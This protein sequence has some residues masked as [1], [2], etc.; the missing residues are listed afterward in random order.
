M[1]ANRVLAV[2][3]SA[4]ALFTVV[5]FATMVLVSP[6]RHIW[7]FLTNWI[8]FQDRVFPQFVAYVGLGAGG[9]AILGFLIPGGGFGLVS[10]LLGVTWAILISIRV[11]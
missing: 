5:G 2:S 1:N 10:S 8:G 3:A 9:I 11:W 4:R 6:I 7:F